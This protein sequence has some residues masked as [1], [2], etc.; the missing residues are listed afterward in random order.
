MS[1]FF[2]YDVATDG[3]MVRL[4][5]KRLL[6]GR[7]SVPFGSWAEE[8]PVPSMAAVGAVTRLVAEYGGDPDAPVRQHG[9]GVFLTHRSVAGLSEH[10]AVGLGL[11]PSTTL[12]LGIQSSGDI[13]Q[14]E[15]DVSCRWLESGSVNASGVQ[16]TGCFL[17]HRQVPA[18]IPEPLF[19]IWCAIAALRAS[20]TTDT[21]ERFRHIAAL[22]EALPSNRRGLDVHPYILNTT[23]AVASAFSLNFSSGKNGFDFDPLLFGRGVGD[24][25]TESGGVASIGESESLLSD[26]YQKRFAEHFRGWEQCRDRYALGSRYYVY[27]EPG[28]REALNV[29]RRVQGAD[30]ETRRDFARDPQAHLKAA[31]AD[32]YDEAA[33]ERMFIAT[34]EYSRR[35]LDLAVWKP[36]VLPWI[37]P[38]PN[39]WLPEA[40][41]IMVGDTRVVIPPEEVEECRRKLDEAIRKGAD[42][43]EIGGH[44]VPAN[45]ATKDALEN[46]LGMMRP[47]SPPPEPPGGTTDGGDEGKP[48][49]PPGSDT[50]RKFLVVGENFE[51][52]AFAPPPVVRTTYRFE[53]PHV[54]RTVLKPHQVDGLRWLEECWCAGYP[55]C[56]LADDMGLGKSL[57]ALAFLAWLRQHRRAH[58]L[59]KRP[60]LG[61]VPIGLLRNWTDEIALHLEP[62][63]L[64]DIL[65]LHGS[66]VVRLKAPSARKGADT[67][68]GSPTLDTNRIAEA[69]LV[70]TS[71]DAMRDYHHS[72]AKIRFAGLFYD[73]VQKLKNPASQW[74]AAA[75]TLNADF[76]IAMTG[77]P[78]ENRAEDLW[79]IMDIAYP[80][81]LPP[82]KEFSQRYSTDDPEALGELRSAML[83]RRSSSGEAP[84]DRP[85]V[86]RSR[87]TYFD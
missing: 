64:G 6:G 14:P 43:I 51:T 23:V 5:A 8:A 38:V 63:S 53:V 49:E 47:P 86:D 78:I 46:L 13:A 1:A 70:L 44:R 41:G 66:G 52:I 16:V 24:A 11:P 28:L 73:E 71:Y 79:A 68:D 15:F 87:T 19:G 2:E 84:G 21:G 39:S 34:E 65:A 18:R 76:T 7:R 72:F 20:D 12:M 9:D 25:W 50:G 35:V 54:L 40:F 74:A 75:K 29:V 80:G 42:E 57:Q 59:E 37:K 3:V 26:D 55:G 30:A 27:V 36:P 61:V 82:L 81:Y 33:V 85:A 32:R 58:K 56:L 4:V 60:V 45:R 17:R 22:K 31:L 10:Q 67:L 69:D 62:K 48:L 83:D 77:T